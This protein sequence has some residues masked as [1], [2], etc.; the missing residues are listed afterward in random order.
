MSADYPCQIPGAVHYL[1]RS[2]NLATLAYTAC[3]MAFDRPGRK[4][5]D[6]ARVTC[7]QCLAKRKGRIDGDATA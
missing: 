2:G 6:W 4:D 1:P 3:G 5:F 7:P